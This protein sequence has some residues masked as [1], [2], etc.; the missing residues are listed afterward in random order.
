MEAVLFH[1]TK[2]V[3]GMK[4]M[5][6]T[7]VVSAKKEGGKVKINVESAKGGNPKVVNTCEFLIQWSNLSKFE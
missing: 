4:F 3:P 1:V 5:M 6:N 2:F 7:K